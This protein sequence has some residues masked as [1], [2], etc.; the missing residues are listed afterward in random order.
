MIFN[1]L[2]VDFRSLDV[3][4]K[5]QKLFS[6]LVEIIVNWLLCSFE[7]VKQFRWVTAFHYL[8]FLTETG[9]YVVLQE[10]ITTRT[11]HHIR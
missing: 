4:E 7:I 10:V 1:D 2:L 6:I 5:F 3:I 11:L 9:L 8:F